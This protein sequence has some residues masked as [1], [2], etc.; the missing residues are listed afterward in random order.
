MNDDFI[1]S[2]ISLEECAK[3]LG[4]KDTERLRQL[5]KKGRIRA[6]KIGKHWRVLKEQL[7]EDIYNQ[8]LERKENNIDEN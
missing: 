2:S 4:Y 7:M 3:F 5:I 6:F 8:Q 1:E